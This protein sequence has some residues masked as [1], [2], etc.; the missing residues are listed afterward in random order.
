MI[1]RQFNPISLSY[2]FYIYDNDKLLNDIS[3]PAQFIIEYST[4]YLVNK[5]KKILNMR[6]FQEREFRKQFESIKKEIAY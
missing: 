5:V 6:E 1:I 4:D 2:K 3:I